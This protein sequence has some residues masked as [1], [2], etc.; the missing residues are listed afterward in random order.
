MYLVLSLSFLLS[1]RGVSLGCLSLWSALRNLHNVGYPRV[2]W[3]GF[4]FESL[5]PFSEP[6]FPL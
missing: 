3:I 6:C 2:P 1:V 4:T 5:S